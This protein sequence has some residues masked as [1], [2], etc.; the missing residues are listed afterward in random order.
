MRGK[1]A[2][3]DSVLLFVTFV[4]GA[5]FTLVQNALAFIPVFAFLA[6]RFAVAGAILAGLSLA[7][8][9]GRAR[10]FTPGTLAAGAVLGFWLFAGY[11]LQTV[12]LLY[13]TPA[14]SGFL[15]G[16]SV[17]MVPV[18]ARVWLGQST[19][20]KVWVGV[21]LSFA[22]I[23][24]LSAGSPGSLG[25]GDLLTIG[26]AL[27]FAV[28]IVLV[29]KYAPHHDPLALTAIQLTVVGLLSA[30][31]AAT[32]HQWAN[33]QSHLMQQRVWLALVICTFLATLLAYFAQ[34]V[35]QRWTTAARTALIFSAEPA[36]AAVVAAF[37]GE[38]FHAVQI[39]GGLL[40]LSGMAVAE[41]RIRRTARE[42]SPS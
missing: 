18:L 2:I 25:E 19:H 29:G 10:L 30:A 31:G 7:G 26:C 22:G 4:W 20:A 24:L 3:A 23:F 16:L 14:N 6:L 15:T 35:I 38:R 12:G 5:T 11:A 41:V 34:I 42:A 21:A 33:L 1:M 28:Q 32:L 13:T 17:V 39:V 27:A 9:Q 36:F 40:I 37:Y 8:P